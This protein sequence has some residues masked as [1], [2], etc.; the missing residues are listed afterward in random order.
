VRTPSPQDAA[1]FPLHII[2]VSKAVRQLVHLIDSRV[3]G[4][5]IVSQVI[6]LKGAITDDVWFFHVCHSVILRM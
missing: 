3:I 4:I 1:L 5:E 6:K 2:I